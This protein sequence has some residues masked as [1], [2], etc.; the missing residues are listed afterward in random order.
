MLH[1]ADKA[2]VAA[3]PVSD[4]V[5]VIYEAA[6]TTH[7]KAKYHVG[8]KAAAF[9]WLKRILPDEPYNA[10]MMKVLAGE[11]Q[12]SE[13]LRQQQVTCSSGTVLGYERG[14]PSK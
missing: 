2:G 10:M 8:P 5:Q 9:H 1:E 4:V 3:I 11:Y 12:R 13:A 6:T 7:P 14:Q